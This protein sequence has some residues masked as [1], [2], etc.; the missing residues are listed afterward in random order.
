MAHAIAEKTELTIASFLTDLAIYNQWANQTLV[1]WLKTKPADL[2]DQPV[3]SS[4]PSLKETLLHIWDTERFW[5]SVLQQTPPPQSFRWFG[6]E[7][8]I[9]DVFEGILEQSAE[10]ATYVLSLTESNL[11]EHVIFTS[12]WAGGVHSRIEFL[13]HCLNH[14][15][16]HR[17]QVITIGRNVGLTDAPMTDYSFYFLMK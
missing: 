9:D 1:D 15:S 11:Q 4:F 8:T 3:P 12:P 5:L 7:G 2:M 14:S 13:Q 6:F 16:Y 10:M 17:G